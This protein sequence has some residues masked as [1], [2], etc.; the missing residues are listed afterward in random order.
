MMK[1]ILKWMGFVV[2]GLVVVVAI[3]IAYVFISSSTEMDHRFV[4]DPV[5]PP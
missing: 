4:V 2:A 5:T 1:K 3:G